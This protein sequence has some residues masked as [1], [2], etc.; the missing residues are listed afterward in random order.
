MAFCQNNITVGQHTGDAP[1]VSVKTWVG[2][3]V[4]VGAQVQE[5][6]GQLIGGYP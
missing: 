6:R 5:I 3:G 2:V 1:V 4:G